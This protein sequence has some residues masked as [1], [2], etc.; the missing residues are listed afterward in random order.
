M[1]NT[2]IVFAVEESPEG[3]F[4][5]RAIGFDIFT[6]ADSIDE[7]H[8]MLRDAVSCHFDDAQRPKLI[9]IHLMR[10]EVIAV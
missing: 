1:T 2:E 5:A 4:E 3:G 9:R 6:E 7:L 8:S 10:D